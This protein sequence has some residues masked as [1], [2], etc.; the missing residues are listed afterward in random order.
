MSIGLKI[1]NLV[2]K[3]ENNTIYNI[4]MQIYFTRYLYELHTV[5]VSLK[6]S[7]LERKREEALFWAYE[8]YY[9]GFKQRVW[10]FIT[11]LYN[12]RRKFSKISLTL[13]SFY[14]KWLKNGDDCL[15]GTVVGTL[16]VWNPTKSEEKK[17]FII[18]YKEPRHLTEPPI[19]RP[20]Q[21][22][23]KVSKYGVHL[24]DLDLDILSEVREAYFSDN[25]LYYCSKT[26]IWQERILV[27]NGI[28]DDEN[29]RVEFIN[30]DYFELF[31][32]KWGFEPDE[33]P[34]EIHL[35]HGII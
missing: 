29:K 34:A 26:P 14:E 3:S 1:E 10:E 22:L 24:V 19:Y 13:N 4:T 18:L 8:I 7:I 11:A 2:K 5:E 31:Y 20:Y 30:D 28:I 21:Y 23:N 9:S 25:W 17:N 12:T 16:A 15:L 32:D 27:V 6:N 35:L 33:Q